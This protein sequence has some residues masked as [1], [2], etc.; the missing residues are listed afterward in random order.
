[1]YKKPTAKVKDSQA[2]R[3]VCTGVVSLTRQKKSIASLER[4]VGSPCARDNAARSIMSLPSSGLIARRA[5]E[6]A[7]L[8]NVSY[9]RPTVHASKWPIAIRMPMPIV[10]S[11]LCQARI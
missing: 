10:S 5:W 6:R 1:V 8:R 7:T 3:S 2:K 9:A 4:L 11:T